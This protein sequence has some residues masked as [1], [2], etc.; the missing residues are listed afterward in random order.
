MGYLVSYQLGV[1]PVVQYEVLRF[2]VSI[3]DAFGMQIGE[4]LHHARRVEPG[5]G[6]LERAPA[7][8]TRSKVV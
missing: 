1:A 3:N 8:E 4:G 5:G 2:Q 6:V 7:G